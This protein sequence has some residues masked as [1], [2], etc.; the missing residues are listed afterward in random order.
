MKKT[1]LAVILF[2]FFLLA[3]C[4]KGGQTL[5]Q[6][7]VQ[8]G[9]TSSTEEELTG[10]QTSFPQKIVSLSPASTEILFALGAQSQIAAV[11]DFS[12]YP[13]EAKTLPSVGGFD[14]KTLSIE[15]ILGFNPDFVYLTSGMHDFLI[16]P[17][18]EFNVPFY[19]SKGNSIQD[20]KNE[21]LE[22]G[23]ITG[24]QENA[25]KVIKKIDDSLD[26]AK[27][28]SKLLSDEAS[29]EKFTVF[30]EVWNEP[31]MTAGKTSFISDIISSCGMKNVF[32]DLE[33]PYPIVS[34]EA[35]IARQPQ[36]ILIPKSSGITKDMVKA[37]DGWGPIPA[38]INDKIY[39][40]DDDIFTRPGPRISDAVEMLSVI[41]CD[42]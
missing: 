40:I 21:I 9:Q 41:M 16:D 27:Q 32:D 2:S 10:G 8:R 25:E 35:I 39:I 42:L 30:Y 23:K 38:V 36:I 13:P 31:F 29:S 5:N 33:E 1:S 14:G 19:V 34:P 12:D 4:K 26:D 18:T 11:T 3:G 6:Q 7:A 22:I 15:K 20:V 28:I 24:H 17:L 37:R